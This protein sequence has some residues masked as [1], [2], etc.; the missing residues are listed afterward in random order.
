M[1]YLSPL[2]LGLGALAFL[3]LAL[4]NWIRPQPSTG[5]VAAFLGGLLILLVGLFLGAIAVFMFPPMNRRI[6]SRQKR[7]HPERFR[8]SR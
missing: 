6:L 2:V 7:L 8:P 1:S 3:C 5:F 4:V